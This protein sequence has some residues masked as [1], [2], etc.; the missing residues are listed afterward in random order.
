MGHYA[1][2]T[3]TDEEFAEREARRA[4]QDMERVMLE[5]LLSLA[6]TNEQEALLVKGFAERLHNSIARR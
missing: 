5:R 1:S 2:E 4:R 6:A 3:M